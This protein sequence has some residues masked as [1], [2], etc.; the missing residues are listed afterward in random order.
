MESRYHLPFRS[1]SDL[2][3]R[4]FYNNINT[5]SM[6]K[7]CIFVGNSQIGSE[8]STKVVAHCDS[9]ITSTMYSEVCCKIRVITAMLSS[10]NKTCNRMAYDNI[11]S[12]L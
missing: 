8:Y 5:G 4:N 12:N 1:Y 2:N 3:E 7:G 6:T 10:G 9:P 11:M